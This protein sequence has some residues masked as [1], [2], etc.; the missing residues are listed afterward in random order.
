M[1]SRFG[2]GLHRSQCSLKKGNVLAVYLWRITTQQGIIL[3]K[4]KL[5]GLLGKKLARFLKPQ[6]GEGFK[7]GADFSLCSIGWRGHGLQS[8][9]TQISQE[10]QKN[11]ANFAIS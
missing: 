2:Q 6:L 1:E 3:M 5:A 11:S 8:E 9:L 7:V 10:S 4:P